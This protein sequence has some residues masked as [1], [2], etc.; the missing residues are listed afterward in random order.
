MEEELPPLPA[1]EATGELIIQRLGVALKSIHDQIDVL[2]EKIVQLCTAHLAD[3]NKGPALK[4]DEVEY[5]TFKNRIEET[6]D[7]ADK[8]E[9]LNN[10]SEDIM[11]YMLQ[12]VSDTEEN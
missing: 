11:D 3:I 1:L 5:E 2:E 8:I 10:Q 4:E 9:S 12:L 7:V 6:G